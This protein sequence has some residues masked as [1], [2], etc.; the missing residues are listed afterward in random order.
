M[1]DRILAVPNIE[2]QF[3]DFY[4]RIAAAAADPYYSGSLDEF[5]AQ[6]E[7]VETAEPSIILARGEPSHWVPATVFLRATTGLDLSPEACRRPP[8][9]RLF[10]GAYDSVFP[11]RDF[12][13]Q[14]QAAFAPVCALY[15]MLVVARGSTVRRVTN[16][17]CQ[18]R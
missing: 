9:S 1:T 17:D 14:R 11:C 13:L 4:A 8:R 7:F 16:G 3:L 12:T 5:Y 6:Q 18:Q 15:R 10:A 2:D